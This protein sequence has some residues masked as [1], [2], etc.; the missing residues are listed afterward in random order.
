MN[1]LTPKE[2]VKLRLA[3]SA[4]PHNGRITVHMTNGLR[5]GEVDASMVL[6]WMNEDAPISYRILYEKLVDGLNT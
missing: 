3:L 4:L 6:H 5:L 2:L 1:A